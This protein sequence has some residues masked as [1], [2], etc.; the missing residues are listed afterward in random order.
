[1]Q[2]SHLLRVCQARLVKPPG[3]LIVTSFAGQILKIS[4]DVSQSPDIVQVTQYA[5]SLGDQVF[6]FLEAVMQI[7]GHTTQEGKHR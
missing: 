3:F 6:G 7:G 5:A 4:E 2:V 1:M